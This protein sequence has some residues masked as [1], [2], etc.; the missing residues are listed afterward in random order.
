MK[1]QILAASEP[2]PNSDESDSRA[3]KAIVLAVV[4][5]WMSLFKAAVGTTEASVHGAC[6][7]MHCNNMRGKTKIM[8][9]ISLLVTTLLTP[10]SVLP[11]KRKKE[12][13]N[14]NGCQ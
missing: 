9:E 4:I 14:I 13:V 5:A 2:L 7:M 8:T 3:G 10:H 1:L 6:F 12:E 11:K